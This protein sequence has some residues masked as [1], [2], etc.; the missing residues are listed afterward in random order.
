MEQ[1]FREKKKNEGKEIRDIIF[2]K[3]KTC[4]KK[5]LLDVSESEQQ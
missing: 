1:R 4:E 3:T 2:Y 5:P